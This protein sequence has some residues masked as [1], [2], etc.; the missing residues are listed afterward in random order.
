[1]EKI[2][3]DACTT[4]TIESHYGYGR[5]TEV[6][7]MISIMDNLSDEGLKDLKEALQFHD[8]TREEILREQLA[9]ASELVCTIQDTIKKLGDKPLREPARE[10]L[11]GIQY[12]IDN[13]MFE[14]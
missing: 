5:E 12:D 13:S 2:E 7:E 9:F 8:T 6:K 1:M 10:A 4:I 11:K 14:L 3:L